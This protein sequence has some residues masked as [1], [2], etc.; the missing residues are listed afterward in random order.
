L[1]HDEKINNDASDN[2]KENPSALVLL[3]KYTSIDLKFFLK[4]QECRISLH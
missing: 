4:I 1:V 3:F 2:E